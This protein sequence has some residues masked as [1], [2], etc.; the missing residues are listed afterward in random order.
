VFR[1]L[2][3]GIR[4]LAVTMPEARVDPQRD[5]AAWSPFAVLLDHVRRTAVDVDVVLEH[6]FQRFPVE[7]VSRVH[8][9]R[10]IADR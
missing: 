2:A 8:D 7:D 9:G 6:Q 3:A 10:G 1:L 5:I 4:L